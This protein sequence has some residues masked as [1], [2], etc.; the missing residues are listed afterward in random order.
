M[1]KMALSAHLTGNSG[2]IDKNLQK[3]V[4]RLCK[5]HIFLHIL[6]STNGPIDD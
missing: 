4:K 3:V 2:K 6:V 5:K 1:L